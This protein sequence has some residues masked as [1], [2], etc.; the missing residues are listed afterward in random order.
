MLKPALE[1]Q[2]IKELEFERQM[3]QLSRAENGR[4]KSRESKLEETT[5][6]GARFGAK[7]RVSFMA[8]G[9]TPSGARHRVSFMAAGRGHPAHP[10]IG[11]HPT[12]WARR[13]PTRG[14]NDDKRHVGMQAPW[15]ERQQDI[16]DALDRDYP[17][18]TVS[19]LLAAYLE[20]VFS[21]GNGVW[22]PKS[23]VVSVDVRAPRARGL[24]VQIERI[25]LQV[26]CNCPT[27]WAGHS[28]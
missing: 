6:G 27:Q 4:E 25:R 23:R 19:R 14:L 16:F 11:E 21:L 8:S 17:A 22:E 7:H 20:H 18:D 5:A 26:R 24:P 12:Q 13:A 15:E 2:R 1:E 9:R 28:H 10:S 3:E